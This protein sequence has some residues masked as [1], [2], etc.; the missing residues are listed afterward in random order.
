M[1][2]TK[3]KLS[4][5]KSFVDPTAI[6][7]PG[8]LSGVIGP[9]GCGKSNVI[10]AVR[11]V[12]GETSAKQLR[13]DSMDDVIF[14]GSSA[15]PAVSKAS[16]ELIFDNSEHML[17]GQYAEYNEIH[18]RREVTR[19]GQ[20]A[21]FLNGARCRR[22]DIADIF[23]GTGLGP[24]SYAI[25]EQGMISRF[26][27]AKP[28]DLRVY[29]EE[30]A[31][32][33]KYKE[34]RRETENRIRHTRENLD[35]LNDL[36]EEV[37]KQL[38]RLKRQ[39][40]AAERYKELKEEERQLKAELI[41]L[42]WKELDLLAGDKE[43]ELENRRTR[44]EA[45]IAEQRGMEAQIEKKREAYNAANEQLNKVQADYYRQGSE[46]SKI[47]QK[48]QH[49]KQT[50]ERQSQDLQQINAAWQAAQQHIEDDK[51]RL[52]DLERSME[53]KT[54]NFDA[55]KQ[56]E[57]QSLRR[58]A[59]AQAA[60]QEWQN[61]W[62]VFN[63]DLANATRTREVET[64][65]IMQLDE[66]I[67][68]NTL[69][70]ER[71]KEEGESISLE[72]FE[73]RLEELSFEDL[74][75]TEHAET[76]STNLEQAN[77]ALVELRN[78][79]ES[80]NQ[81]MNE[82][83]NHTVQVRGNLT[84]LQVLQQAAL[85]KKD[86]KTVQW[87]E[88]QGYMAEPRL[89]ELI[90][91]ENG[92]ENAVEAVLGNTL[93]AVC[94]QGVDALSVSLNT[95]EQGSLTFLDKSAYPQSNGEAHPQAAFA[96]PLTSKVRFTDQQ[97]QTCLED[98]LNGVYTAESLSEALRLRG[99]LKP[100]E[101]I[102]SHDG[103]WV[104]PNW[105][106][107]RRLSETEGGILAREQ[108]IQEASAA[109][110]ALA[111][112]MEQLENRLSEHKQQLSV[113]EHQREELQK[114]IQKNTT[115]K[116]DIRAELNSIKTQLEQM[117]QRK[118][119]LGA[120]IRELDEQTLEDK[121]SL[122]TAKDKDEQ[123][124]RD[125]T[126]LEL[127]RQELQEKKE[128]CNA[129]LEETRQ[130]AESDRQA[131]QSIML[132]LESMR[133]ARASTDQ[134]LSRMQQQ[135]AHLQKRRED[136]LQALQSSDAPIISMEAELKNL[137]EK[138][139]SIEESLNQARGRVES[140]EMEI[141][142]D[143]ARRSEFEQQAHSIRAE[144]EDLRLAVQEVRVRCQTLKEQL[145]ETDYTLEH[146]F[147]QIPADAHA[148]D[149]AEKLDALNQRI[150]RMGP[151]NLAAIDEHKEQAERKDYLDAQFA[152]LTSAL[153]TLEEAIEKIDRE[154]RARFKETFELVNTKL[155]EMFPRL[156]GGGQAHLEMTGNDLLST[157][158]AIMARPPGKRITNIHLLSGGE[159]ALTAVALVFSLFELNPAP[160]CMLDEVDAPLDEANVGRFSELVR[161]MSS[162]VQFIVI[163]H[164]KTTMERM[165]RLMGV[166]MR[167]AGVSRLVAVDIDEA[168]KMATA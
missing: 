155:K 8:S 17:G 44:M 77:Q 99:R 91:V 110:K 42:K 19:D 10:D 20:S 126:R 67:K 15:R 41:A 154:T 7:F 43:K 119:Q 82:L 156:F 63:H 85:G 134:N 136:L 135:I 75:L 147:A 81:Q 103:I 100:G 89:A 64:T 3:I 165:D 101:S 69:R 31:G 22:R 84:S 116:A 127:Q 161:D 12:M 36:R 11:W 141:R 45:V 143:S 121:R 52:A 111:A 34:R 113:K 60:M 78:T 5:F 157:G 70:L 137:L 146:L 106:R 167:E 107:V 76:L 163:T 65:R 142:Q 18:V 53:D 159:K 28:E 88:H 90:H 32:I 4:G 148:K 144:L 98:L 66:H 97:H 30:A 95:L 73:A 130:R 83:R 40:S 79:V 38:T 14:N 131:V 16:V 117:Q 139:L 104:G 87:L 9:N 26:V 71:L 59:E 80:D 114:A 123:A 166:T 2:L 162:R 86:E 150:Q 109:L 21:Y 50:I 37:E 55:L 25:I 1:R 152:D 72:E 93:E 92:W 145:A 23:L 58:V 105:L 13:G 56:T 68:R 27:E 39:A 168:V 47:E 115:E 29:L 122:E 102:V 61:Q 149:W 94:I 160:F 138:Q 132:D 35:R 51:A 124:H 48:I 128:Q 140:L 125:K 112:N 151:I 153:G 96:G 33:S 133:T 6:D 49:H 24:R 129:V 54:P 46:I 120:E 158:V 57:E 62:E 164:N 118:S 74:R 108:E